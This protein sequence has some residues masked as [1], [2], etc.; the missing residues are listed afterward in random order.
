MNHNVAAGSVVN[1]GLA[2]HLSEVQICACFEGPDGQSQK[3]VKF[4]IENQS[5]QTWVDLYGGPDGSVFLYVAYRDAFVPTMQ[6]P[7]SGPAPATNA[8][9][10]IGGSPSGRYV[11]ST[12]ETREVLPD[13]VAPEVSR[14]LEVPE[15][16]TMWALPANP[17]IVVAPIDG[18]MTFPTY[19]EQQ[20][21]GP[22]D[23]YYGE[24]NGI[25]AWVFYVPLPEEIAWTSLGYVSPET[26]SSAN[27]DQFYRVIGV[28]IRDREGRTVGFS[29]L[30][31]ESGWSHAGDF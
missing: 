19:V 20:W 15:G 17:N 7:D 9:V 27:I 12:A 21:L 16:W 5:E 23:A 24:G 13:Q 28:G 18:L 25:G 4:R 2:I 31:P 11:F 6:M 26:L 10:G 30:P 29:P 22:G 14:E 8:R 1:T 3:K